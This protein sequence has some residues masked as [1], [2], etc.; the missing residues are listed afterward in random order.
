[1]RTSYTTKNGNKRFGKRQKY[2]KNE[3]NELHNESRGIV[4]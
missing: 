4:I 2:Y 1:M 3:N